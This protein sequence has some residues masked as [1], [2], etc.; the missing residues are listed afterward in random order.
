MVLTEKII[1]ALRK[2]LNLEYYQLDDDDGISGY[3]VSPDFEGMSEL[4]RQWLIDDI[5]RNPLAKISK[6]DQRRILIIAALTP[7]EYDSVPKRIRVHKI[8]PKGNA[9]R[10]YGPT[11]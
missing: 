4:D 6:T 11:T 3:V 8:E 10:I 2:K 7:L 9:S 1:A 5:L